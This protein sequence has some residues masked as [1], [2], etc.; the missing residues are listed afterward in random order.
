MISDQ[1]ELVAEEV[2]VELQDHPLDGQS[3]PLDVRVPSLRWGQLSADINNR[4]FLAI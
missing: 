4:V 1:G 3:L 2:K